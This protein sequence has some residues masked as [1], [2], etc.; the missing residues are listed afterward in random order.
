MG[1]SIR[2]AVRVPRLPRS[3]P[4]YLPVICLFIFI[5]FGGGSPG[6]ANQGSRLLHNLSVKATQAP[7]LHLPLS[8]GS[9]PAP[10]V[11]GFGD[12]SRAPPPCTHAPLHPRSSP[13]P[14]SQ[15]SAV[16]F[17]L[18]GAPT[19]GKPRSPPQ[20][21]TPNKPPALSALPSEHKGPW[22]WGMRW[23]IG[24]LPHRWTSPH[25]DFSSARGWDREMYWRGQ[26]VGRNQ[27][28]SPGPVPCAVTVF[29][30]PVSGAHTAG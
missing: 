2:P 11:P 27:R 29:I 1:P 8:P 3:F 4:L 13:A 7:R 22:L 17:S 19:P 25:P 6:L 10:T 12:T 9:G 5:V 26:T 18:S 20:R 24:T 30:V 16:F 15:L 28:G 14:S 21:P 23:G